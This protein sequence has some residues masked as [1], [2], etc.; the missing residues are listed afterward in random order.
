M[1]NQFKLLKEQRFRPYFITAFLSGFNDN[2]FKTALIT[3]IAFHTTSLAGMDSNA[4]VTLLPGVFMLPY[5]L[6]SATAGQLADKYERASIIRVI[7]LIEI[8]IML[9]ASLGF[10]L[11]NMWLL[12]LALFLMGTHSTFFGPIK[13]AYLPQHLKPEELMGGNGM[14]EMGSFVAIL[15]GQILGAWLAAK[16][17]HVLVTSLAIVSVAIFGYLISRKIPLTPAPVP[18]LNVNWNPFTETYQNL[19][20][21]W[22]N[23]T[24][25]VAIIAISWFWFFGATVVA[26]LPTI[27]KQVLYGDESIFILLLVMFSLGVGVGSLLCEKLSKGKV[28]MGLVMFG[29]IGLTVFGA[30]FGMTASAIHATSNAN[31]ITDYAQFMGI[32]Q[33]SFQWS[34]WHVLL[35]L[36]LL[37]MFGGFFIVPLYAEIQVRCD[38]THLSRVIAGNNIV[39]AMFMVGSAGLSV[40][41]LNAGFSIPALL[42]ITAMLNIG[43]MFYLCW[44]QPEFVNSFKTWVKFWVN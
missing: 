33:A 38:K 13:F 12:V 4:L 9:I 1:T 24:I 21:S 5:F 2:L 3:L 36:M 6:F 17:N 22:G 31:V 8:G 18:S 37:G 19:K 10:Y 42:I 11:N 25:W 16:T 41:I 23:Q 40:A 7:K 26:Q 44:R 34:H 43:V 35:D 15:L 30:D 14:V 32:A 20:F 28:E 27:A 39:N 29:A